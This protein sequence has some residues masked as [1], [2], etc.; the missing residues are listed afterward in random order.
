MYA[1]E[2]QKLF[3]EPEHRG[4]ISKEERMFHF[5]NYQIQTFIKHQNACTMKLKFEK[6]N[7]VLTYWEK[8]QTQWCNM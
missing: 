5:S 2:S 8:V 3:E 6:I 7:L 4:H 1:K